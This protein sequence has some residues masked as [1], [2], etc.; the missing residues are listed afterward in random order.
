[1]ISQTRASHFAPALAGAQHKDIRMRTFGLAAF[2]AATVALA[3][4]ASPQ[5]S[6]VDLTR[7]TTRDPAQIPAMPS[8]V[9]LS[10]GKD[11]EGTR[12]ALPAYDVRLVPTASAGE[13]I[14]VVRDLMFDAD[15]TYLS[16][17]DIRRLAP[18]QDYLSAN[19]TMTVLIRGYGDGGTSERDTDLSI[20][21][22]SA[23]ARA[24]RAQIRVGNAIEPMAAATPQARERAGSA[25]IIFVWP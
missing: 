2:A 1:L 4:C 24:L 23:V 9:A 19:P 10:Y 16:T 5:V 18:L 22:A 11:F 25:E 20:S 13:E 6:S 15:G 17:P 7:Q 8:P 14:S 21:R 3:S 12:A